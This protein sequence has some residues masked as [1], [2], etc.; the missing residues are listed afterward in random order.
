MRKSARQEV[1][2]NVKFM[3]P[4]QAS[5]RYGLCRNSILAYAKSA[6]CLYKFGRS[7]RIKVSVMDEYME[8]LK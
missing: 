7:T 2:E 4:A 3:T 8:N 6:D 1:T 5:E